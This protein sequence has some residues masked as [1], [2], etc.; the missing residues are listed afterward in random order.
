MVFAV[1]LL[2]FRFL[3]AEFC[4][5]HFTFQGKNCET[6]I[7]G[8]EIFIVAKGH[9]WGYRKKKTFNLSV[10]LRGSRFEGTLN[11]KD[12]NKKEPFGTEIAG[13]FLI[14]KSFSSSSKGFIGERKYKGFI[15][16]EPRSSVLLV[17]LV[18]L[19]LSWLI[20]QIFNRWHSAKWI[21]MWYKGRISRNRSQY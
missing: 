16:G 9:L 19:P 12:R 14:A 13:C 1:C 10:F 20:F 8:L 17:K 2:N 21:P 3:G 4:C 6:P 5:I 7:K 18:V 15:E 11:K